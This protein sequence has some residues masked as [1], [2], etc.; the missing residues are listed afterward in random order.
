MLVFFKTFVFEGA[1][2]LLI[3]C[4]E[5]LTRS[6]F[7]CSFNIEIS[8]LLNPNLKGCYLQRIASQST[9]PVRLAFTSGSIIVTSAAI[10]S[11]EN[12]MD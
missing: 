4:L 3:L 5:L 10:Y 7:Y 6:C 11:T 9:I 1:I 12:N 8:C 2:L